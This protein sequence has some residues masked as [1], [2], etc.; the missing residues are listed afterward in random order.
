[1][2]NLI[3]A[4]DKRYALSSMN[5]AKAES[6]RDLWQGMFDHDSSEWERVRTDRDIPPTLKAVFHSRMQASA[7]RLKTAI[8]QVET[9]TSIVAIDRKVLADTEAEWLAIQTEEKF[10]NV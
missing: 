2:Q 6:S 8:Q 9:A 10:S 3:K 5:L 7:R 4:L 1:M